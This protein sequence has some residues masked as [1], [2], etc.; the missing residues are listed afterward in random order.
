L[1]RLRPVSLLV[2]AV[3][4]AMPWLVDSTWLFV[5]TTAVVMA[6]SIS[7]F[8]LLFSAGQL[9]LGH[10]F[11]M[12]LGGF[13]YCYFSGEETSS[14]GGLDL[15]P[16]LSV[17]L[18]LIVSG[19]A[20]LAFGPVTS[21]LGGLSLAAASLGLVF[22]GEHLMENV[23]SVSGGSSG[24][25]VAPLA[26]GDWELSQPRDLWYLVVTLAAVAFLFAHNVARSRVGLGLNALRDGELFAE[27]MGVSP[28][29]FKTQ[30]FVVSSV[31]A[32][33][34]GV[35]LA[36]VSGVLVPGT[37]S[38]ALS[39]NIVMMAIL[40]GT[41]FVVL[42]ALLG[43]ALYVALPELLNRYGTLLPFVSDSQL[44]SGLTPATLASYLYGA[45]IILIMIVQP[46]GLA[47]LVT[48]ASRRFS[49]GRRS[50][51]PAAH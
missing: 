44:G 11:F 34:S 16:L 15:H 13:S 12:A 51:Q 22:L 9:S 50:S 1:T 41:S 33:L 29:R 8:N 19:V 28:R 6:V 42:G 4:L 48:K 26:L 43:G 37:F 32:G 30:A 46:L 31:Y 35:L 49:R 25:I 2:V 45:A 7:G 27:A 23:T 17:L 14:L 39:L 3:V 36:L 24:R 10:A 40:G 20:G 18:A 21:R 38:F 47:G 5:A